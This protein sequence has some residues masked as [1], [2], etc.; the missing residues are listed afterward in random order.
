MFDNIQIPTDE[1]P[2]VADVEWQP[3]DPGLR[4][5]QVLVGAIV[6]AG[7]LGVFSIA[8]S[9]T[10]DTLRENNASYPLIA[11]GGLIPLIGLWMIVWPFVSVP[12]LGYAVRDKDVLYRSGVL[13]RQVTAIPYNRIQ[14]VEKDTGPLDRRFGLAN[15]K[16][17]TA[18]GAG[19]DLRISGL[20]E[21]AAERLRGHILQ[22]IGAAIEHS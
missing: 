18:G 15:L 8:W 17:F 7:L 1:L 19:G 14:H 11:V 22:R 20:S 3:M 21:G 2:R 4:R 6:F 9:L 10:A 5:Q 12:R 13:W 16:I